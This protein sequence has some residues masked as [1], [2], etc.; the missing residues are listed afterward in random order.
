MD[1]HRFDA[2]TNQLSAGASRRHVLR[3]AAG[4]AAAVRRLSHLLA[5]TVLAALLVLPAFAVASATHGGGHGGGGGSDG[6]STCVATYNPFAGN[7]LVVRFDR[8]G[9]V[10]RYYSTNT[11]PANCEL[12]ED[13]F[14]GGILLLCFIYPQL[15]FGDLNSTALTE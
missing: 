11:P 14:F 8:E 10:Q 2:I 13:G 4:G 5:A 12:D 9:D 15:C 7:F 6:G 3:G 1:G